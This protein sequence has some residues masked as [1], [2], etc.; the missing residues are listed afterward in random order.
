MFELLY[1]LI[2]LASYLCSFA[3]DYVLRT[4]ELCVKNYINHAVVHFLRRAYS[5]VLCCFAE[6]LS[7]WQQRCNNKQVKQAAIY[8]YLMTKQLTYIH[9]NF[10]NPSMLIHPLH[11]PVCFHSLHFKTSLQYTTLI[12]P[13]RKCTKM[14]PATSHNMP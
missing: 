6:Y 1:A 5:T 13:F 8:F 14:P 9:F 3:F 7:L 10:K 4:T 2:F 11:L 12:Y